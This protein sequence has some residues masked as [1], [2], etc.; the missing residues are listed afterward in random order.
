MRH[1]FKIGQMVDFNPNRSSFLASA[2][3]YEILQL[4]PQEGVDLL[5]RIKSPNEVFQRIAREQDLSQR[6]S[7]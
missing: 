1:K 5:Y 2:R 4:L 7:A 6:N 3:G